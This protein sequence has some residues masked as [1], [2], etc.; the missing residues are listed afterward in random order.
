MEHIGKLFHINKLFQLSQA[1]MDEEEMQEFLR[2][3]GFDGMRVQ[4]EEREVKIECRGFDG[5]GKC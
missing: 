1:P 2:K 4:G 5:V 3:E